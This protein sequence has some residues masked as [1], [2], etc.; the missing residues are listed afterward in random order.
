M[1]TNTANKTVAH[2]SIK[3]LALSFTLCLCLAG[4]LNAADAAD[5]IEK[6][7]LIDIKS[8]KKRLKT[9]E[10]TQLQQR[11]RLAKRLNKVELEVDNL[12]EQYATVQ[13]LADEKTIALEQLQQRL[14]NWQDQDSY[15]RYAL[16]DFIS[17][18]S[19]K[20][21]G[22][23]QAHAT[24]VSL[25]TGLQQHIEQQQQAL[26]PQW[27]SEKVIDS[28]G[29]LKPAQT[30]T[31][32]PA[33]WAVLDN[34]SGLLERSSDIAT[35]ALENTPEQDQQWRQLRQIGSGT[36]HLDPSLNRAV[37]LAQQQE[38]VLEHIGKGGLWAMPILLFGLIAVLCAIAKS[39]QLYRLPHWV[40]GIAPRLI[41]ALARHDLGASQKLQHQCQGSQLQLLT[42][43]LSE[44]NLTLREDRLFNYL[45]S[46]RQKLEKWLGTIAV[47]AAVAPLL[48]LLG[49]V[50]GMIETFKLM[51]IFGS[52]DAGAVSG[53][54]SEAL[55]TTELGLIVAIPALLLHAVLQR[56][57]KQQ[58]SLTEAFAIELSQLKLPEPI[59]QEEQAA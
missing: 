46:N 55:V 30:L 23:N 5:T 10:D 2:L 3:S 13:R 44:S 24:L 57:V 33:S 18:G 36:V 49:T 39:F 22:Q 58:L 50:S 25:L 38:S 14:K 16:N 4:N 37:K 56:W 53:G 52:G 15:Q 47:I 17:Q 48:G 54:I 26:S 20:S 42:I 32:G 29:Q 6:Q 59:H 11:L 21:Q 31:L 45:M 12:R 7:L 35:I 8:A 43:C 40:P 34:S 1:I 9:V 27:Q 51:A 19:N 28:H 41:N